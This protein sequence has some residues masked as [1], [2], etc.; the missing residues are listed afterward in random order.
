MSD[1]EIE[2]ADFDQDYLHMVVI[3]S[4]Q[5][6]GASVMERLDSQSSSH[7]RKTFG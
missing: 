6:R 7:T 1:V 4:P 3:I 2:A 5:Y